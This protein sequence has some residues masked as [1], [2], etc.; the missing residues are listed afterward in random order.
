MP[1]AL[2]LNN[3]FFDGVDEHYH[4]EDGIQAGH[5]M[6][7]PPYHGKFLSFHKVEFGMFVSVVKANLNLGLECVDCT[8]NGALKLEDVTVKGYDSTFPVDKLGVHFKNCTFKSLV[9]VR[10]QHMAIDR[11]LRFQDCTFEKG[12]AIE[13]LKISTDSLGFKRC[14]IMETL[15]VFHVEASLGVS[16]SANKVECFTRLEHLTCGDL[17]FT[18][19]NE[20]S[21]RLHISECAFRQGII[22]N[23]GLFKEEVT[24]SLITTPESGLAIIGSTF[25]RAVILN[26]HSGEFRTQRGIRSFHIED[27]EFKNGFYANGTET[28]LSDFPVLDFIRIPFSAELQ[29][30]ITFR[31]F[32]LG[33][34]ELS[35]Y[36]T[37]A[38]L[39]LENILTNQIKIN[40]LIN[41]AG[42]ILSG[43]RASHVDWAEDGSPHRKRSNAVYISD[44]N[45]GK[46]QFYQLNFEEFETVSFHNII[47]TEVST[48]LVRWPSP[49]KLD[50]KRW[51]KHL[52]ELKTAERALKDKQGDEKERAERYSQSLRDSKRGDFHRIRELYRQLKY[53]TDKL[54]DRPLALEFQRNEMDYYRKT[55]ALQQPQTRAARWHNRGERFIL[56]SSQSNS[57]G[58]NWLKPV[59]LF[60][61]FSLLTYLPIGFLS[62]TDIDYAHFAD[63]WQDIAVNLRVVFWDN[64]KQWPQLLNPAHAIR[65]VVSDVDKFPG[66]IHFFDFLSR[67]VAAYFIFQIV[68]AFRKF[69]K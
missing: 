25:E 44:S 48:S 60:A 46:A 17:S 30:D 63:S 68:S 51:S 19:S 7:G 62:S 12:I 65:Q 23:D 8:F 15:D 64:L 28:P 54:G 36:N 55:V 2:D 58:Q 69:I 14:T 18:K 57:F 45:F 1:T 50:S 38:N 20:F 10:G 52:E 13:G 66:I 47:L 32:R 5:L 53:I 16:F 29:G 33:L 4:F 61:F 34:L 39:R 35:G 40:G 27:T 37:G 31:N 22:F 21:D 43:V 3:E 26:F 41:D 49:E 6:L 59:A 24:L 67:V 42:L 11:G 56:W 9:I